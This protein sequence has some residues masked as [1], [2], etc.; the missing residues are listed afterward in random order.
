M[1]LNVGKDILQQFLA[2]NGVSQQYAGQ[3]LTRL[4]DEETHKLAGLLN[5]PML[6]LG[7]YNISVLGAIPIVYPESPE[8]LG[9]YLKITLTT[10]LDRSSPDTYFVLIQ[11][12]Q[13]KFVREGRKGLEAFTGQPIGVQ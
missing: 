12:L 2:N 4:T 10:D 7:V 9:E 5:D 6:R 3:A 8:I 11:E 1:G 13:R